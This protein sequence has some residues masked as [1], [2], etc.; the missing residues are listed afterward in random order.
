[1]G[2]REGKKGQFVP[3]GHLQACGNYHKGV[4]KG[5]FG[6]EYSMEIQF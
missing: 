1:M 6:P 2:Y 3:H 5:D 4:V